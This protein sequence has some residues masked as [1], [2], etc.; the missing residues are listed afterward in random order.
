MPDLRSALNALK[1]NKSMSAV[2]IDLK[3]TDDLRDVVHRAVE[4]IS[5]GK[6]LAVPTETVYGL[7]VS[8]LKPDAVQRLREI[9]NGDA[10][11]P[12][13]LAL[14]SHEEALDYAPD[15]NRL[16]RRLSQ[17]CW[18]GPI[19]LVVNGKHPDSVLRRLDPT[20]QNAVVPNGTVG[21]RVP[22]HELT[23]QILRLCAGPVILTSASR[24]GDAAAADGA[25]VAESLGDDVDVI[26]N[27]GPT[28]F[29]KP[30]S[31]VSVVDDQ[32][33]ILKEGVVNQKTL[34]R[35]SGF[36]VIIVCTGNTC[37]SP[38][39][40][41]LMRQL[42][43]KKLGCSDDEIED[44]GVTVISAGVSASPG[45]AASPQSVE[46]MSEMGIDLQT[47]ASQPLTDS[48]ARFA[49]LILTMTNRHR[50]AIIHHW[51]QLERITHVLRRDGMDIDDPIG[52]PVELYRQ[53]ASQLQE[54]LVQWL[55]EVPW[56]SGN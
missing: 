34:Q 12:L 53:C 35:A 50:Q 55:D 1:S 20:V 6:I 13:P 40:E 9:K 32:F 43:A 31:V 36:V 27:D 14:R 25:S 48:L 15:M 38:M 33:Q 56:D 19:T 17:R 8:A 21:L 42:L 11:Q 5:A 7:A 39:G 23:L 51:P 46:V 16:A 3:N 24:N 45:G 44:R 22:A 10:T 4:T 54:N 41:G 37:R 28:R 47:H 30:S 2:T 52:G 29:E 18:P 26:L 49:D